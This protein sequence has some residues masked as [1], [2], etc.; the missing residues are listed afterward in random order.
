MLFK[1]VISLLLNWTVTIMLFWSIVFSLY[2]Q[3][4]YSLVLQCA[5]FVNISWLETCIVVNTCMLMV[6]PCMYYI[7]YSNLLSIIMYSSILYTSW[8]LEERKLLRRITFHPLC[9][10]NLISGHYHYKIIILN[11]INFLGCVSLQLD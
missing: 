7:T 2:F 5:L 9:S 11:K 6:L 4:V 3:H 10:F 1:I 8:L